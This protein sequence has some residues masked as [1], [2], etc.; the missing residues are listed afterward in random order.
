LSAGAPINLS[1]GNVY[2]IQSDVRV[3]G[4]GGGLGLSRTWNSI[5]PP[6]QDMYPFMFGVNWR[7][8]YEERLI[9]ATGDGYL[10]YLRGDGSLWFFAIASEGPPNVY[11][12]AAPATDTTTTITKG[13]P[14]WTVAFRNGERRLFDSTTGALV[15]I[16]DRNGNTTSLFYDAANRLANVTDAAQR[17]LYFNYPDSSTHLVSSVTSDVGIT[18]SYIFDGQG[19]LTQVAK[20]DTTTISFQYDGNSNIT[21]VLD[22]SGKILESHTYD[23]LRRGLT[24]SR[25]NGVEAVTV[26]Y[27]Q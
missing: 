2:I 17:H 8:N 20:P 23:V 21:A 16:V 7:S 25:A 15:S 11:K 1:T 13:S 12:A 27:P 4:L 10:R 5:L 6:F 24:S 14:T 3:P 18:L 9:L 26:T 19:R 22:T